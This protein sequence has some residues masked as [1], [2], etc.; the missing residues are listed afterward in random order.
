[1]RKLKSSEEA[2]IGKTQHTSACSDC[3]WRRD[4]LNGWLGGV[5]IDEWIACA[6]S[7]TMV[8]CH[9]IKNQQCAGRP[10]IVRSAIEGAEKK[11]DAAPTWEPAFAHG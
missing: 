2:V 10:I 6:H 8:D 3:P 7:E 4:S 5:S 9:T 11:E 1:M